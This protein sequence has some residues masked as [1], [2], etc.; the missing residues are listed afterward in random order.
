M[1]SHLLYIRVSKIR[2]SVSPIPSTVRLMTTTARK[3]WCLV[4]SSKASVPWSIAVL[5]MT[6]STTG[7]VTTRWSTVTTTVSL[8]S[9]YTARPSILPTGPVAKKNGGL[10]HK[11]EGPMG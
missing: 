7:K 5:R 2:Q 10:G 8:T 11:E 9:T 3:A 6:R 1:S 4:T